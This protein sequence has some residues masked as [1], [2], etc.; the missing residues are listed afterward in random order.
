MA[1]LVLTAHGSNAATRCAPNAR[2]QSRSYE[3]RRWE[4]EFKKPGEEL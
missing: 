1:L 3:S 2:M 4:A